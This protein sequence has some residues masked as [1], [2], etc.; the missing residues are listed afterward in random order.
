[1]SLFL[2]LFCLSLSV[3]KMLEWARCKV[4][5][6]A[7]KLI[8]FSSSPSAFVLTSSADGLLVSQAY[9]SQAEAW[10]LRSG[11]DRRGGAGL[12]A[13]GHFL[14]ASPRRAG[15]TTSPSVRSQ[16]LSDVGRLQP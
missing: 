13:G 4:W 11:S 7:Q 10:M 3:Q 5:N 16:L 15:L 8:S 9:L 6:G 2:P 1:M 14:H 12:P